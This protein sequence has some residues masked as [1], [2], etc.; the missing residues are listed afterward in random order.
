M[1]SAAIAPGWTERHG[2]RGQTSISA[3]GSMAVVSLASFNPNCSPLSAKS[4]GPASAQRW[5][6]RRALA[7]AF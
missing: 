2:P 3:G 1:K 4:T 7:I 5:I 6:P